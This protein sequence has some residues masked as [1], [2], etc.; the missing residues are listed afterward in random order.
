MMAYVERKRER[1]RLEQQQSKGDIA[2]ASDSTTAIG[3][4]TAEERMKESSRRRAMIEYVMLEGETSTFECAHQLGKLCEN[5]HIVVNLI[6]YN[7]TDVKDKLHCPSPEHMK[8]FKEIVQSYGTFCTIRRT[9]GA[10]IASAC[11]QLVKKE[12]D[13]ETQVGDIEDTVVGREAKSSTASSSNK[14]P[15]SSSNHDL[16]DIK[17]KNVTQDTS[18]QVEGPAGW[19]EASSIEEL[20]H[21]AKVLATVSAASALFFVATSVHCMKRR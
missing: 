11:G 16:A 1:K 13:A 10:D 9:M 15:T 12:A 8:K 3:H 6:P 7:R 20:E 4:Y 5:R 19:F 18:S 2:T 14:S 17:Y 21:Y